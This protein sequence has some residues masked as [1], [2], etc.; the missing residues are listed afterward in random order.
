VTAPAPDFRPHPGHPYFREMGEVL[1]EAYLRYDFTR[2]TEQETRF[3]LGLLDLPPAAR[4]LDVGCGPG[5]HAVA[6]AAHGLKVTGIDVSAR[7]LEIAAAR[8]RAA[9]VG[10]A[11]FECDARAMP[12]DDEFDAVVAL[13]EGAFG[14]MGQDD[15]LVLKR[16]AEAARPGGRVVLTAFSALFEARHPRPDAVFDADTGIVYERTTIK[17]EVGRDHPSELW[18]SVYTPRE[19]RLLA[20]GCGLVPEH[21][22]GVSPGD[23]GRRPPD[24]DRP[25]LMLVAR[26]P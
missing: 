15:A 14:V 25:E 2:G 20:I 9:G 18:T 23:Y 12:F 11:F 7:F 5:R 8:C 19:L 4:I 3:L 24:F 26:K 21:V 6:L 10:A 16:M 22:W 1:G 13:C 17:D